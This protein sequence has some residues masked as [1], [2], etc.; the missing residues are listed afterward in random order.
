[1]ENFTQL[2]DAYIEDT[3]TS[4]LYGNKNIYN[5]AEDD[6]VNSIHNMTELDTNN[7][8][9]FDILKKIMPKEKIIKEIL[10]YDI[11]NY[12]PENKVDSF[13][14]FIDIAINALAKFQWK[15]G[16]FNIEDR[17]W[18]HVDKDNR[19]FKIKD[20][21]K[22]LYNSVEKQNYDK[23][24][25]WFLD[26]LVTYVQRFADDNIYHIKYKIILDKRFSI[27]W[28]VFILTDKTQNVNI[29]DDDDDDDLKRSL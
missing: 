25:S 3:L 27:C 8:L 7:D 15:V 4:V 20:N 9:A 23:E 18:I 16:G 22:V 13:Q 1:M 6:I 17:Q 24:L 26:C 29:D 10:T 2:Q 5:N 21:Q 28:T 12:M 19:R 11:L 14:Q